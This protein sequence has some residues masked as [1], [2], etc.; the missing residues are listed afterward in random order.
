MSV[1]ICRRLRCAS[2]SRHAQNATDSAKAIA[3]NHL[4]TLP[5]KHGTVAE[6]GVLF[7]NHLELSDDFEILGPPG[8]DLI[9]DQRIDIDDPKAPTVDLENCGTSAKDGVIEATGDFS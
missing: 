2:Y 6:L 4:N 1:R 9:F 7:A 5:L 8:G 3:S